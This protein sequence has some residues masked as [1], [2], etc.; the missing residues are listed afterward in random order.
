MKYKSKKGEIFSFDITTY[1]NIPVEETYDEK[2]KQNFKVVEVWDNGHIV[3]KA[4]TRK[5]IL[6]TNKNF[7]CLFP[8]EWF[9]KN[10][11]RI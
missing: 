2:T 7:Y 4:M 9:E 8:M 5:D 11:E 3:R 10:Y 6:V 1:E